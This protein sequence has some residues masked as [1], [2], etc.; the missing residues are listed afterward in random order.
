MWKLLALHIRHRKSL[1]LIPDAYRL[2]TQ[3]AHIDSCNMWKKH[4]L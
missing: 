4:Y 1:L 2:R 3:D